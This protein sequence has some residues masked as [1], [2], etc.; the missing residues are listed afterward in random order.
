[1]DELK[2]QAKAVASAPVVVAVTLAIFVALVWGLIHWSYRAALS[3]KDAQIA[4]LQ[5]S[6][7]EYR[8]SVHGASPEDARRRLDALEA[9]LMTLRIR[10]AP[11]RLTPAQQQAITDR[12]LRPGGTATRSLVMII[13]ENCSDC[14]AFAGDMADALRERDNWAPTPQLIE[15]VGERSLHGLAIRMPDP[16]RPSPD[17]VVLQQVL[18]SAGLPFSILRGESGSAVELLITERTI[19]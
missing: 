9:E 17:A 5:R 4:F 18:R 1:M 12:S 2:K 6:V 11:R 16:G 13:E 8:D 15:G 10:L 3:S 14:A 19:P 7:A